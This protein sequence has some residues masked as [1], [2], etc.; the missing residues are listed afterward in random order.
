MSKAPAELV[1]EKRVM[2]VTG[3]ENGVSQKSRDLFV[4][5]KFYSL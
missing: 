2:T 5:R 1:L 4:I 3:H